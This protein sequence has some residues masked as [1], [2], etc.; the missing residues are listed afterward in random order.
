MLEIV[1]PTI[2]GTLEKLQKN[3]YI[4][5][6]QTYLISYKE[7]DDSKEEV[8]IRIAT[9][10]EIKIIEEVE[11]EVLAEMGLDDT[12]KLQ[13]DSKLKNKYYKK[14]CKMSKEKIEEEL[15]EK[16]QWDYVGFKI[17]IL[18]KDAEEIENIKELKAKLNDSIIERALGKI[19]RKKYNAE[20]E[21][22]KFKGF[23]RPILKKWYEDRLK[24]NYIKEAEEMIKYL[25]KL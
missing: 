11:K 13:S 18:D 2:V 7:E 3:E 25:V 20:K 16:I 5:Y 14:T 22:K 24:D 6:V 17:K 9:K 23:G 8:N 19:N 4:N 21:L 15:R 1:K 12:I 10:E